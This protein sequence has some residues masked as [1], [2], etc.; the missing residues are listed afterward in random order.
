M[1]SFYFEIHLIAC[2][3]L[4]LCVSKN[5]ISLLLLRTSA[6]QKITYPSYSSAPL[7]AKNYI[8]LLFLRA[9]ACKNLPSSS[10]SSAPLH[11][12]NYHHPPIP[13]HVSAP[14]HTI[15]SPITPRL[16]VQKIPSSSYSSALQCTSSHHFL[17]HYS[18]PL[19]AK[20]AIILLFLSTSV[21]LVTP[22]PLPLLRASAC[23]NCHLPPI[24]QHFS[25]PRHTIPS[26]N[27]PRLCV[28][29]LPSSSY[30]PHDSAPRHT[31]PSPIPPRLCVQNNTISPNRYLFARRLNSKRGTK[32]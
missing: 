17:S 24:P 11:A 29:K 23:K 21:Q 12:K 22:F 31:I 10:Y 13:Q 1:S 16:C 18:A 14:R 9:S 5:Y 7:R 20:T 27:P 6:Y 19:R 2:H 4:R 3:T 26:P 32:R 8:S 25:A 15:P 30:S 28:Q